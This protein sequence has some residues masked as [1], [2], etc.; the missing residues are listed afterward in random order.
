MINSK[1]KKNLKSIFLNVFQELLCPKFL[2]S[3]FIFLTAFLSFCLHWV[4]LVQNT[5]ST[6]LRSST[7]KIRETLWFVC[8]FLWKSQ[9]RFAFGKEPALHI[10]FVDSSSATSNL[11]S[12][13]QL[14][15][16]EFP[17]GKRIWAKAKLQDSKEEKENQGHFSKHGWFQG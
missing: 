7:F 3:L 14:E 2:S 11:L 13:S 10:E 6:F 9:S 16:R 8:H 17:R 12:F 4:L 1:S 15:K 5:N